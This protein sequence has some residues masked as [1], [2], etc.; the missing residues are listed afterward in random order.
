MTKCLLMWQISERDHTW[1]EHALKTINNAE[2]EKNY[3][4]AEVVLLHLSPILSVPCVSSSSALYCVHF[5]SNKE[6]ELLSAAI[7]KNPRRLMLGT[8]THERE[9]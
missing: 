6:S 9:C 8:L 2:N 4:F 7:A 3:N 1:K 5:F